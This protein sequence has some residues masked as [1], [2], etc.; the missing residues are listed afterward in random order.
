MQDKKGITLS[1]TESNK[2]NKSKTHTKAVRF[3]H[4][5]PKDCETL[6]EKTN[7]GK[8][9]RWDHVETESWKVS[10]YKKH[11]DKYNERTQ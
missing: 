2:I 9:A 1:A 10:W 4:T 7:C 6:R 3:V 11:N 8:V 5:L